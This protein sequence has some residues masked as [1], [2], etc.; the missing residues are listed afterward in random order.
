MAADPAHV[1]QLALELTPEQRAELAN[2][3]WESLGDDQPD[4]STEVEAAWRAEIE[5]RLKEFHEG[6]MKTIPWD[7]ALKQFGRE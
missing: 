1:L 4:S 5:W 3:L 6:R 2:A 7:E